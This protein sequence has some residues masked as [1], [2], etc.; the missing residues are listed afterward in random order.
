[1]AKK[2]SSSV[3]KKSE[4]LEEDLIEE[5]EETRKVSNR[6]VNFMTVV[7]LIGFT[8]IAMKSLFERDFTIYVEVLWLVFLGL[9]LLIESDLKELF[10]MKETGV[11]SDKFSKLVTAVVGALAIFTGIVSLP[12]INWTT[13]AMMAIKGVI[14]VVAIIFILVEKVVSKRDN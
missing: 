6:F 9:G 4:K 5:K 1:M 7:S 2:K 12:S 14:A 3:S 13:P 11:T 10:S 8:G